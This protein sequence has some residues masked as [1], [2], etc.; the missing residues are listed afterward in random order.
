MIYQQLGITV[1]FVIGIIIK[2]CY[3]IFPASFVTLINLI[4]IK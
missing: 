2:N 1:H 4:N 3:S